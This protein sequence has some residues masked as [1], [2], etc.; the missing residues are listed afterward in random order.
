MGIQDTPISGWF[1][2]WNIRTSNGL[3][4]GYPY[5]QT[6]SQVFWG[7]SHPRCKRFFILPQHWHDTHI[8]GSC[9]FV[10]EP[11]LIS[12]LRL[13]PSSKLTYLWNI[14]HCWWVNYWIFFIYEPRLSS[15]NSPMT[16]SGERWGKSW[17]VED[18]RSHY[19]WSTIQ[20]FMHD[21]DLPKKVI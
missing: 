21:H 7:F 5:F 1:M 2:S 14:T 12:T 10:D 16:L 19:C 15:G 3:E 17:R 20:L 6:P 9:F 18:S 8:F 13:I 4:L 11:Y